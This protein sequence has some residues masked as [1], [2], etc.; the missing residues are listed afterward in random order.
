LPAALAFF[1]ISTIVS[2]KNDLPAALAFFHISKAIAV[3][4]PSSKMILP[5]PNTPAIPGYPTGLLTLYLDL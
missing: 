2:L 3:F 4:S 1:H 5:Q